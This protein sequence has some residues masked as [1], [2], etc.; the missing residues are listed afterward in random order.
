MTE[1]EL[2]DEKTRSLTDYARR[3]F[4]EERRPTSLSLRSEGNH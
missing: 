2:S 1:P 3:T 4:A